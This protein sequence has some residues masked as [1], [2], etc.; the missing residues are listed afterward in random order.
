[1]LLDACW[2]CQIHDVAFGHEAGEQ[3]DQENAGSRVINSQ[4]SKQ[5]FRVAG[6][7]EQRA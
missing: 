5:W 7:A 6:K 4:D 1:M 2:R 3:E